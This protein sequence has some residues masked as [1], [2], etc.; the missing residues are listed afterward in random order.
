MQDV[1]E[2]CE[3]EEELKKNNLELVRLTNTLSGREQ[4]I[5][6][7]KEKMQ[8]LKNNSSEISE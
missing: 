3:R 4:I 6:E 5:I 7:L 8:S 2:L 1:A